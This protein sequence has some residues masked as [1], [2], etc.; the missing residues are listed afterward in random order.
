MNKEKVAD[1][2]SLVT[3]PLLHAPDE[4]LT[5]FCRCS[6]SCCAQGH[7][8]KPAKISISNACEKGEGFAKIRL[9][10]QSQHTCVLWQLFS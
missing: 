6:T 10:A 7:T 5:G 4:F 2:I 8:Y 3:E 9:S 1:K